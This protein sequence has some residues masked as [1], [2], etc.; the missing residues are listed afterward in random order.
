M[1]LD[2]NEASDTDR[3]TRANDL[4]Y[5]FS[6]GKDKTK[7]SITGQF[8]TPGYYDVEVASSDASLD[9]K[10]QVL[11]NLQKKAELLKKRVE[12]SDQDQAKK[13]EEEIKTIQEGLVNRPEEAKVLE[14]NTMYGAEYLSGP[15]E[16][17]EEIFREKDRS[18]AYFIAGRNK[19]M[20]RKLAEERP[21]LK[22]EL[23]N[24]GLEEECDDANDSIQA[25]DG[26]TEDREST[27]NAST[28]PPKADDASV[29]SPNQGGGI[30]VGKEPEM[31]VKERIRDLGRSVRRGI[32]RVLDLW[33]LAIITCW[34]WS[35]CSTFYTIIALLFIMAALTVWIK[36]GNENSND[37]YIKVAISIWELSWEHFLGAG[38]RLFAPSYGARSDKECR[39]IDELM[40]LPEKI[41]AG[42]LEAKEVTEI[43]MEELR[44]SNL[45]P[46]E[47][48]NIDPKY[49]ETERD[50]ASEEQ[51]LAEK[52]ARRSERIGDYLRRIGT[53]NKV[54]RAPI[55]WD[56]ICQ[57]H[58]LQQH[59]DTG[60]GNYI[61]HGA[62]IS[63]PVLTETPLFGEQPFI[64]M[65]VHGR[66]VRLLF[67]SGANCCSFNESVL[68][69]IKKNLPYD[70]VTELHSKVE[71]LE[72]PKVTGR[73]TVETF[74]GLVD[75]NITRLNFGMIGEPDKT[76]VPCLINDRKE[77]DQGYD[78]IIG[79]NAMKEFNLGIH[80]PW[81]GNKFV[82]THYPEGGKGKKVLAARV[83]VGNDTSPVSIHEVHQAK[84]KSMGLKPNDVIL[85][86]QLNFVPGK[87]MDVYC[88]LY[89]FNE[90]IGRKK[91]AGDLMEFIPD[92]GYQLI[93]QSE[94]LDIDESFRI[95][96]KNIGR[97][98]NSN[99]E[100]DRLNAPGGDLYYQGS[101]ER[102]LP[103]L[104][105]PGTKVG[106]VRF[107]TVKQHKERK[108][109]GATVKTILKEG[110][111]Q[112][113]EN[114]EPCICKFRDKTERYQIMR[115]GDKHGFTAGNGLQF[116]GA[117]E[118]E[119]TLKEETGFE[120]RSNIIVFKRH[121][122][123]D[124]YEIKKYAKQLK[125][126][127]N[128]GKELIVIR[129]YREDFSPGELQ[130]LNDLHDLTEVR[131][132]NGVLTH[133]RPIRVIK[134]RSNGC[135]TCA[136]MAT[137]FAEVGDETALMTGFNKVKIYYSTDGSFPEK[138]YTQRSGAVR[139]HLYRISGV[140]HLQ[141]F[142][143]M[144]R[145]NI[146]VHMHEGTNLPL[147]DRLRYVQAYLF[148]QFRILRV[149]RDIDILVPWFV[150]ENEIDSRNIVVACLKD[151]DIWDECT[152][153]Y[154]H[155][156]CDGPTLP[157][158]EEI[159][160]CH[161][162]TC[163]NYV[164][165]GRSLEKFRGKFTRILSGDP[166]K[167]KA[168]SV[169]TLEGVLP[170]D[171]DKHLNECEKLA[172]LAVKQLSI[173][174][175]RNLLI[176]A[177]QKDAVKRHM[178]LSGI[179]NQVQKI[180]VKKRLKIFKL[181]LKKIEQLAPD[182]EIEGNKVT[183]I[184]K[185][186]E[187]NEQQMETIKAMSKQERAKIMEE[188]RKEDEAHQE[189]IKKRKIKP[190]DFS[191][192]Q[193]VDRLPVPKEELMQMF[194]KA[195]DDD[196]STTSTDVEI[197]EHVKKHAGEFDCKSVLE[198]RHREDEDWKDFFDKS[199]YPLK[200][201]IKR[202]F[203]KIMDKYNTTFAKRPKSWRLM[204]IEPIHIPFDESKEAIVHK[205]RQMNPV[206]D[207][208]LTK[209]VDELVNNDLLT[210]VRP[211]QSL[212]RNITR[213]FLVKHNSDKGAQMILTN[214]D[215]T[216]LDNI[217]PDMFRIV[218]DF[219][220][221]N[222]TILNSGY[223][224]YVM[225][226]P[227]EIVA[228]MGSYT[229]FISLD[230]KSAYRSVPVDAETRRRM[231][232]RADSSLYRSVLLEFNSLVDGISVAPQIFTQIITEALSDLMDRV[233]VWI[234]D[235]TIMANSATEALETME[236]VLHRLEKI[237]ALVA[238]NK[239]QL[240]LD[241][242]E[243]TGAGNG[244]VFG[245]M[246]FNIKTVV[247][248]NEETGKYYCI[249]K[250]C[251]SEIKKTLFGA[252]KCPTSYLEVQIRLGAA[253]WIAEFLPNH[254]VNMRPFLEKLCKGADEK[255]VPTEEMQKAWDDLLDAIINAV[256]LAI[257]RYDHTLYIDTDAS[258]LGMGAVM[259]QNYR[260]ETGGYKNILGYYSKRFKLEYGIHN[261]YSSVFREALGLDYACQ[262]WKRYIY[263][264]VR[265]CLTIDVAAVTHMAASK[266]VSND[267]HLSRIIGRI[268]QLGTVFRLRHTPAK[269]NNVA[270]WLSR[271]FMKKKDGT[272]VSAATG[273]PVD[274]LRLSKK[275]VE[276]LPNGIPKEWIRGD[277]EFTMRQLVSNLCE[278]IARNE[279][280]KPQGVK[281]RYEN[282]LLNCHE[283]YH[284]IIR[285]W[286]L[287]NGA[288][289]INNEKVQTVKIVEDG[290]VVAR[291]AR[292]KLSKKQIGS[293]QKLDAK[294][295][296]SKHP[297]K[298]ID[299]SEYDKDTPTSMRNFDL[300]FLVRLQDRNPEVRKM[301][302]EIMTT[303][304]EDLDQRHSQFR[305]LNRQL[306]VTRKDNKMPF[307]TSNNR[308]YL[309]E[310]EA[311]Y[312]L[313]YLHMMFGHTGITGAAAYFHEYFDSGYVDVLC[314]IVSDSCSAC[315]LYNPQRSR[316]ILPGRLPRST[317]VG[318]KAYI[319]V[320]KIGL[321]F[322][323]DPT[324][325]DR[326][327]H[328]GKELVDHIL[329][330]QDS[331]S[332]RIYVSPILGEDSATVAEAIRQYQRTQIPIAT[333]QCDNAPGFRT[334][335]FLRQIRKHGI[336]SVEYTLPNH[337]T[338][339]ARVERVIRTVRAVAWK[340][341][342]HNKKSSVW[343]VLGESVA[344]INRRPCWELKKYLPKSR[345][346][347]SREDMYYGLTPRK[348]EPNL[349]M[350][351]KHLPTDTLA[352]RED[353]KAII[354]E[355]NR[356]MQ[357][358]LDERNAI[359]PITHDLKVGNFVVLRDR[360]SIHHIGR[361]RPYFNDTIYKLEK[362]NEA[363][364]IIRPAYGN[365]TRT[366]S[367]ALEHLRKCAAPHAMKYMPTDV[368][369]CYGSPFTDADLTERDSPPDQFIN[370][371][372]EPP[373]TRVKTRSQK[374]QMK[375]ETPPYTA[376]R[377]NLTAEPETYTTT[378][379]EVENGEDSGIEDDDEIYP[380]KAFYEI[381]HW[382][383]IWPEVTDDELKHADRRMQ[384]RN[385]PL[386]DDKKMLETYFK[387][388]GDPSAA[389]RALYIWERRKAEKKHQLG[390]VE[391]DIN[392]K[393]YCPPKSVPK[394]PLKE[395][396]E[397]E[398]E[399]VVIH[400]DNPSSIL[401]N[402]SSD[403]ENRPKK[404]VT[405]AKHTH[406][407]VE[408]EG[409]FRKGKRV[410]F[411][412]DEDEE[413]ATEP[414]IIGPNEAGAQDEDE[415]DSQEN[416]EEGSQDK[417]GDRRRRTRNRRGAGIYDP[418]SLG[419]SRPRRPV[420]KPDRLGL[421]PQ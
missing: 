43:F 65:R 250:L 158:S 10:E 186:I 54:Y 92:P 417:T 306:L 401:R 266:F 257:I 96:V 165:K 358:M 302:H 256:D 135:E 345:I 175:F 392:G 64:D 243:E 72:P 387:D 335:N 150:N 224:D 317:Y 176:T 206:D 36:Y 128:S 97:L 280:L 304:P 60:K 183:D 371:M 367:V 142:R 149:P 225:G 3:K 419:A 34:W 316:R 192:I 201:E 155:L 73:V 264:C 215:K 130:A 296:K 339:N 99:S 406:D 379:D 393:G 267:A 276:D 180:F 364:A 390:P 396:D 6:K 377:G 231:T 68:N 265:T 25:M 106:S 124:K 372:K 95:Q 168:N 154:R 188:M 355:Y 320:A 102:Q 375:D 347:P 126:V 222:A 145:L 207:Y 53:R 331:H 79:T 366:K 110:E 205:Y 394:C 27:D 252:M 191:Y 144:G 314:K 202:E 384:P 330:I 209:K 77:L 291:M 337:S 75:R 399:G 319:D 37:T 87:Q 71:P 164:D 232:V 153:S 85:K 350:D 146:I 226:T 274:H 80:W 221:V 51:I 238:L 38:I 86:H 160:G 156:R 361:G 139:E 30:S 329:I 405:F 242:D 420:K 190:K 324:P 45:F 382:P 129:S 127:L 101:E 413:E 91:H 70:M 219:R 263:A 121:R 403:V 47:L 293:I 415:Q 412:Y 328:D 216:D 140:A 241:F 220:L 342:Q 408:D 228:R 277:T 166:L 120:Q 321:G 398:D 170:E 152:E 118:V 67:D 14:A 300:G 157:I 269:N 312:V 88:N 391:V 66:E 112:Y 281:S 327:V 309:A 123:V 282:L 259:T 21:I 318:Q 351:T 380:E 189:D 111:Y 9:Y 289:D 237:K 292:V 326:R 42:R 48:R 12:K 203:T 114:V 260:N 162:Q 198:Q 179:T 416:V 262:H 214:F 7:E 349:P 325:D 340:L 400:Y 385:K 333:L 288:P 341:A 69:K 365:T 352:T 199:K 15:V 343:H 334:P 136:S 348:W 8:F 336:T 131:D 344:C 370:R 26:D 115:L 40:R 113:Q 137:Q 234:D 196:V 208:I 388:N 100:E 418:T 261:K 303:K 83:K 184:S 268:V 362:I 381:D 56:H 299:Y 117:K 253:N 63:E 1:A 353:F 374:K 376:M 236:K 227:Q 44:K 108:K 185:L 305:L 271:S 78:G 389:S 187:D 359:K 218:A 98:S 169:V 411:A 134:H 211:D 104:Y 13:L 178:D 11:E 52:N 177:E 28:E 33:L 31:K 311:L 285:A 287:K 41:R 194:E 283:K 402:D 84:R 4:C 290:R 247:G 109:Q 105:H 378:Q 273:V 59:V 61:S 217:D 404:K 5:P 182:S 315:T 286:D 171:F 32:N 270:D 181:V 74:S 298:M 62:V 308:I 346:P 323:D 414:I 230:L 16:K 248:K 195:E 357:R 279:N 421:A 89:D 46:K 310:Y 386:G 200:E 81:G 58:K 18:A 29:E 125:P 57:I 122:L 369:A 223:A 22:E 322:M 301:K 275:W 235:I 133:R 210:V 93:L 213:L 159:K 360:K 174:V 409:K 20:L 35:N 76:I 338:S 313:Y 410:K 354:E 307:S 193:R 295:K 90:E 212:F 132:N 294:D 373:K 240:T 49:Y 141:V 151:F 332:G 17:D 119:E 245:H 163:K 249:P 204:D 148:N 23:K 116:K 229:H 55:P 239:M 255:W 161:C 143:V 278:Q 397:E 244:A 167:F 395:D 258:I 368:L 297:V 19:G 50:R 39:F 356:D 147:E 363:E 107:L 272:W 251:I 24:D 94:I 383:A 233:V 246:G 197:E 138:P 172:G 2:T 173:K 103:R 82:I 407:I 254:A 284:P